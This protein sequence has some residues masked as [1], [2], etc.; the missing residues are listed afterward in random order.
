MRHRLGSKLARTIVFSFFNGLPDLLAQRL[1]KGVCSEGPFYN[2]VLRILNNFRKSNRCFTNLE[3]D[4]C[5]KAKDKYTHKFLQ[6]FWWRA[7][8][9]CS[10]AYSYQCPH[11]NLGRPPAGRPAGRPANQILMWA[12]LS[13]KL[14]QHQQMDDCHCK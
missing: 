4:S 1:P 10:Q 6:T 3:Q 14:L 12:Y 11:Q 7:I 2:F 5:Q 9:F 13:F 8:C